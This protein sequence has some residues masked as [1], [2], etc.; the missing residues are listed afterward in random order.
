MRGIIYAL[1][2]Y[3]LLGV[4]QACAKILTETHSVIEVTFYRNFIALVPLTIYILATQKRHLFKT[5]KPKAILFR[6]VLGT[7]S[8]MVTYLA[9]K[10]LP[11]ADATVI[12]FT[13]VLI[14][15]GIAFFA[16]REYIGPHR[17][18]AII[19]G[20]IGVIIMVRPTGEAYLIGVLVAFC[21]ALIHAITNVSLR[22]LK[23]ES[24]L[25]I[26]YY[27]VLAGTII[28]ALFLP[29]VGKMPE[30]DE[31]L[32]FLA[33]GI[34]GGL[35]QFTLTSAFR[36]APASLVTPLN[37]TGLIWATMFDIMIWHYIPGWPV[38]AGGAII[39]A[40]Q[41]YIIHREK[42]SEKRQK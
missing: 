24:P 23:T 19:I 10:L 13:G 37:Y 40:S 6:A 28:P 15:P 3:F 36:M 29:L 34:S 21:A 22:Y 7:I 1:V 39:I 9:V 5:K 26:T 4:M 16:L 2:A 27:F 41:A 35:A 12:F 8:L 32:L 25:T 17:W 42:L 33:V 38:F 14:T 30:P 11:M 18:A 20:I 31:L